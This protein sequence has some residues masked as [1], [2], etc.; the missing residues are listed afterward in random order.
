VALGNSCQIP[1]RQSCT[2]VSKLLHLAKYQLGEG[3]TGSGDA[4]S[5]GLGNSC[6]IP[7]KQ[8]YTER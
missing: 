1:V 5:G 7:V 3:E 4:A 8:S 6:Q 2:D